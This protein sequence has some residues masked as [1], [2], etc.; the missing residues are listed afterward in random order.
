MTKEDEQKDWK[1]LI[2][3]FSKTKSEEMMDQLFHLFLTINEREF[4]KDRFRIVKALLN[5]GKS[6]RIIA[7]ELGTSIAKIT[8]GSNELK[9]SS[10]ELIDFFKKKIK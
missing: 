1:E 2:E 3:L 8:A 5:S 6:Q 4:L 7:S 9:R 10:K